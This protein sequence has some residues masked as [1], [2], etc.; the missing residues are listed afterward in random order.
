MS[1]NEVW[2]TLVRYLY[3]LDS[4]YDGIWFLWSV[5]FLKKYILL[6]LGNILMTSNR[7]RDKVGISFLDVFH[8]FVFLSNIKYRENIA[9]DALDH[10]K[11]LFNFFFRWTSRS[12][13]RLYFFCIIYKDRSCLSE[14]F[15][16]SSLFF[17]MSEHP[18]LAIV[19]YIS[20]GIV[21]V[22]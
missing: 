15:F 6:K 7:S 9:R 13:T 21:N 5:W 19:G 4:F 1:Y 17:N 20:F 14:P 8:L 10:R 11:H 16:I 12:E 3:L 2:K 22:S 18:N